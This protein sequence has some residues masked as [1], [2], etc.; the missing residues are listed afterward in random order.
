MIL[1]IDGRS[2]SGKTELAT[3]IAH[4]LTTQVVRLDDIYPGW[5]GLD[6]GSVQVPLILTQL[7]WRRWDWPTSKYEEWH[8]LDPARDII[9]E[10]CGALSRASRPHADY[11][12]W[13]EH[14]SEDRRRRAT[15]REPGFAAHWDEWAAQEGEFI[16]REHPETLADVVV[17][18]AE[19]S[20]ELPRWRAMFDPAR[21]GE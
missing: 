16:T 3:A 19:V 5:G 20:R 6:D 11:A 15:E 9:I 1:L 2:G 14:E 12:I 8:E 21:V 17:D 4:G 10:G 18:G 7:R 13:V